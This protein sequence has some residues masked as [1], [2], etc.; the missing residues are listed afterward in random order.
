MNQI[1]TIRASSLPGFTDCSRRW[2]ASAMPAEITNAGYNLTAGMP[3]SVGAS[4]GSAV[5][6][7]AAFVMQGKIDNGVL[8]NAAD[9]EECAVVELATQTAQADTLWDKDTMN[10]NEAQQQVIRM[11]KTFSV[12]LA[13][14]LHPIAVERRLVANLS[15]NF[16]L[17]GQSDL[18]VI[19]PESIDDLKTGRISRQHHGQMGAYSLL[20]RTVHP[21]LPVKKLRVN[22]IPRVTIKKPQPDPIVTAYNQ[23]V[24]E[25]AAVAT[26]EHIK[27]DV[28]EFRRRVNEE[29]AAAEHAFLA[30]PAS[31]LCSPKYCNAFGTNFCREHK[32][33]RT[34]E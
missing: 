14:R 29:D 10:M 28:A 2:A 24:S 21:D 3:R 16:V 31:M 33:I 13:P 11:V 25:Q 17:S 30:N 4:I 6:S 19:E 7:G 34:E 20:A 32:S 5:H 23:A 27:K 26:I 12:M 15:D 22:F 8:G 9:A 1:V 18:Q